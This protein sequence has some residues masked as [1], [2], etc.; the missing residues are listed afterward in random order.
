MGW[1]AARPGGGTRR[2][3]NSW[4]AVAL[5]EL[6]LGHPDEDNFVQPLPANRQ[7]R[8]NG[9]YMVFRKLEQD[10]V[11]FR[12]FMK[13]HDRSGI[14]NRLAAQT[15]GRWPD[16]SPFIRY[17]NGPESS[18]LSS[19]KRTINNFRYQVAD[20]FGRCCPLSAH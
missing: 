15:V 14:A 3:E 1:E 17:P 12:N 20:P 10:V 7:L 6:L 8:N 16:G 13:R 18:G 4:G 5:G 11:G 19:F 9:T 2:G